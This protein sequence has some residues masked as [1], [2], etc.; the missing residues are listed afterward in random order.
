MRI[1]PQQS[2]TLYTVRTTVPYGTED[3]FPSSRRY[4]VHTSTVLKLRQ[5]GNV[6]SLAMAKG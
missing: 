4:S 3:H 6:E 5:L 1:F 2:N